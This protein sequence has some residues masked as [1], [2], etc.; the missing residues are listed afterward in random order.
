M[1]DYSKNTDEVPLAEDQP[2]CSAKGNGEHMDSKAR[3][4]GYVPAA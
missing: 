4:D 2:P 1:L 3:A